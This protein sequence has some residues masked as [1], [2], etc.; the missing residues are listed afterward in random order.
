VA[1][2][3]TIVSRRPAPALLPYVRGYLGYHERT[4]T[5]RR[6]REMPMAQIVLIIDLGP[7]IRVLDADGTWRR[8]DGGF[9]AGLD[10][11]FATIE[12][13]GEQSGIHVHI[14]LEHA[15]R[16][17]DMPPR[18]LLRQV[19]R[20]ADVFGPAGGRLVDRL[21]ATTDWTARF[22]LLDAFFAARVG[23]AAPADDWM[24]WAWRRIETSGG[25][26]TVEALA[27]DTGFSRKHVTASFRDRLGMAPKPLARLVRF[28]RVVR[29]L[30]NGRYRDLTEVA[31]DG[32]YFDQAH[33]IR[34]F[35]RFA[36]YTPGEYAAVPSVQSLPDP[37]SYA[38]G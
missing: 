38:L 25:L 14:A 12:T 1:P 37:V 30:Q 16:V 15:H 34:E 11:A 10:D 32:G 23:G 36:G 22:D 26:I 18:A 21:A 8:H 20:V 3:W 5:P 9:F 24:T 13:T 35:R 6:H 27:R 28:E 7:T 31:L 2:E 4:G 19:V 17:L 33:F 29:R